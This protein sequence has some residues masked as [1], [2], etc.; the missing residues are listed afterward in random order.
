MRDSFTPWNPAASRICLLV[1]IQ[2]I[3]RILNVDFRAVEVCY[4]RQKRSLPPSDS[5]HLCCEMCMLNIHC[6]P[7]LIDASFPHQKEILFREEAVRG[8][9]SRRRRVSG[10][11]SPPLRVDTL[12]KRSK[13]WVFRGEVENQDLKVMTAAS[14]ARADDVR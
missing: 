12:S 8:P 6:F 7:S 13:K 4:T 9:N 10:Q 2:D 1:L 5:C 14:R 11:R 3:P